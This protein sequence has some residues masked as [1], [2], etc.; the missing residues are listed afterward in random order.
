MSDTGLVP[1]ITDRQA[2]SAHCTRYRASINILGSW[3]TPLPCT[4][5]DILGQDILRKRLSGWLPGGRAWFSG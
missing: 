1:Y 2:Q 3:D 4:A 5:Y